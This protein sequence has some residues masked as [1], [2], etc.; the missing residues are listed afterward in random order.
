MVME[1]IMANNAAK[2]TPSSSP[3]KPMPG[4]IAPEPGSIPQEA[5]TADVFEAKARARREEVKK[6]RSEKLSASMKASWASG[7]MREVV[8]RRKANNPS[9]K[10]SSSSPPQAESHSS[11]DTGID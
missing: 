2:K 9:K 10:A 1:K 7:D 5:D 11:L 3:S 6:Q 4:V 8:E